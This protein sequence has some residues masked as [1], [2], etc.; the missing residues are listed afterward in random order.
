LPKVRVVRPLKPKP[1]DLARKPKPNLYC[2]SKGCLPKVRILRPFK[3][4]PML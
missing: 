1:S 4:K 2:P 3:P